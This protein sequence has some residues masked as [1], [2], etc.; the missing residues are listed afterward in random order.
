MM[1]TYEAYRSP[2]SWR[3]GTPE[4]RAIWSEVKKRK[5][6]RRIW[7]AL[8]EV[9][10][11]FGLVTEAQVNDLRDHMA[12]V[13]VQRSLE[14]ESQ[15]HH[16]LMAEL[17]VYADQCSLAGGILHLGATSMDIKD[18][19]VVLLTREG[20]DL[21]RQRLGEVLIPLLDLTERHASTPT[22][23]F[24]HLQPAE[25][26]TLGYRFAGYAQDLWRD[27]CKVSRLRKELQ[28]KGFTGAVGTSA[29]YLTL[30]GP[31]PLQ[32]F[33]KRL[34]EKLDLPFHPVVTQTYP[35]RQDYQV[36]TALAGLAATIHKF[37]FDLRFLQS[38]PL[39]EWSEPFGEDQIGSS[40]MPFK[41]NPIQAEKLDSIARLLA[42]FPRVAWD[43]AAL[44]LLE[45][46]LDDSANR[47][48]ILPEAFLIADELLVV[49]RKVISGLEIYPQG[50]S[51]NLSDYGPFA[52]MEPLLMELSKRGAD[53][54]KMHARLRE[55]ALAAWSAVQKG[56]PNP[57]RE[58][59]L[60]DEELL[61]YLPKG[62]MQEIMEVEGYTGDAPQRALGVVDKIREAMKEGGDSI[63]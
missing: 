60:E 24:T 22:L 56:K 31:D 35:R 34:S 41:R 26:T 3:Y 1:S 19:A 25:P 33:Q 57:L 53:R 51:R 63:D 28:G 10:S 23:G 30:L 52:A 55:H 5:V 12:E 49:S 37:A 13:D 27:R 43:N 7:V 16:D 21:I 46:T 61:T 58:L 47:R 11:T 38:P 29:S 62:D 48:T 50:I 45:R 9:Q 54:Q 6:W 39:G 32:V 20:L 15:I 14:V 42:Q 59:I 36:V 17:K 44:S 4:M 40:A 18:N 8:A 2:Y